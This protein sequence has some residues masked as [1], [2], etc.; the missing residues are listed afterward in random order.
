[1]V[2]SRKHFW[3]LLSLCNLAIV[4]LFGLVLR[5]KILFP[6]YFL[7]YRQFLSAHS[8]FAFAGWVG[9]SLITLL[10]FNL[11]PEEVSSKKTYKW[12][13]VGTEVSSLGMALFFP[14]FGYNAISIFFSSLYI[15][16]NYIFG[17][18]YI[19]DL[20]KIKMDKTVRLLSMAAIGSL[21]VS[22]IG[23][24]GLVYI[25]LSKSGDS[26]LYRDSIYTFLHF[27]YNGFFTLSVFALYFSQALQKGMTIP[28]AVKRFSLLMVVSIVPSLF[29]S[30]LWHGAFLDY[31]FAVSGA[32]LILLALSQLLI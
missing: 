18:V 8:H 13:L 6:I 32:L 1:M 23:P 12:I 2:G 27:Q 10:I 28:P 7:D 22:A 25:L 11:L 26:I 21:L 17:W 16:V 14:V 9:L 3:L 31:V 15:L 5:S 20:L 24:L 19:K 29:L 4:A 30:L